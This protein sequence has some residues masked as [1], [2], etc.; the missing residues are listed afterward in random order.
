MGRGF[1][2]GKAF[3]KDSLQKNPTRQHLQGRVRRIPTLRAFRRA[4]NLK[5]FGIEVWRPKSDPKAPKSHPRTSLE[6]PKSAQGS[7]KSAKRPPKIA[8]MR[9]RTPRECA[10]AP[11]GSSKSAHERHKVLAKVFVAKVD[12][13]STKNPS[14]FKQNCKKSSKSAQERPRA[15]RRARKSLVPS[16]WGRPEALLGRSWAAPWRPERGQESQNSSPEPIFRI[17]F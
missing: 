13:K 2:E 17:S 5:M 3:P 16:S 4:R 11:Q 6:H 15:S 1:G 7:S 10:R 12:Q 14:K 8:K 9:P